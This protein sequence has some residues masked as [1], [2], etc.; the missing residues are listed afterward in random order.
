MVALRI[1]KLLKTPFLSAPSVWLPIYLFTFFISGSAPHA[2]PGWE[3]LGPPRDMRGPWRG[4]VF[5]AHLSSS[6][7]KA[8]HHRTWETCCL[9]QS[10]L[11]KIRVWVAASDTEEG[12]TRPLHPMPLQ[13]FTQTW[14]PLR[15]WVPSPAVSRGTQVAK[16]ALQSGLLNSRA[17]PCPGEHVGSTVGS[18]LGREQL[19]EAG[20]DKLWGKEA[21][22]QHPYGKNGEPVPPGPAGRHPLGQA[23]AQAYRA[24]VL[25][26]CLPLSR[27]HNCVIL[28]FFKL[29]SQTICFLSPRCVAPLQ[30]INTRSVMPC[31]AS[32]SV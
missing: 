18:A 5:S 21:V 15:W 25:M 12:S 26:L 3:G 24:S 16:C 32:D 4:K 27:H 2:L 28:L 17:R 13:V 14:M 1:K 31:S 20:C 9:I 8:Q 23:G 19:M 6:A 10:L 29:F 30:A 22:K 7:V 11:P